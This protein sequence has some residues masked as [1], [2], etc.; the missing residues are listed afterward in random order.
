MFVRIKNIL[1]RY[2]VSLLMLVAIIYLSLFKT[3]DF[4]KMPAIPHIDKV[5][6]FCMYMGL[7]M[8]L[9]FEHLRAHRTFHGSRIVLGAVLA[10][11]LFSAGIEVAQSLFTDSRTGDWLDFAFNVLGVL[12]A[13]IVSLYVMRP[14]I[15]RHN[16]FSKNAVT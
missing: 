15:I 2:P 16:L 1:C 5:A 14:F 13:A 6:H 10:P 11:I 12:C 9:W 3:D 4:V 7:C 8:M